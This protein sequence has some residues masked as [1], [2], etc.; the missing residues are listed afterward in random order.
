M[1]T[2][3]RRASER[4]GLVPSSA[5][6][7]GAALAEERRDRSDRRA[8]PRRSSD[9]HTIAHYARRIQAEKTRLE[10]IVD[11]TDGLRLV[12]MFQCGCVAF[13]PVGAGC[14]AVTAEPCIDH[15]PP[16]VTID[17]RRGNR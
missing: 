7:L 13:E 11:G 14:A 4:R 15:A 8:Q 2:F 17:R 9:L 6:N 1:T 10:V 3:D 16:A 12:A 5:I